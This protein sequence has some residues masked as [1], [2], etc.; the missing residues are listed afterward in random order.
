MGKMSLKSH[1]IVPK[2]QK[3]RKIK[4]SNANVHIVEEYFN[5]YQVY[6]NFFPPFKS[7]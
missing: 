7:F 2:G 1:K 5:L 3:S 6:C 4:F